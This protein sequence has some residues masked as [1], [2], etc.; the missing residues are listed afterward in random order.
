MDNDLIKRLP[1]RAAEVERRLAQVRIHLLELRH[2]RKYDIRQI[3]GYVRNKQRRK[4]EDV[5]YL[6]HRSDK[7]KQQRKRY[8]GYDLGVSQRNIRN[9]IVKRRRRGPIE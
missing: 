3:E 5:V 8:A 7:G 4:T 1:R 9:A 2:Y 6:H